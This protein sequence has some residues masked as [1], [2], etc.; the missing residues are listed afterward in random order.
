MLRLLGEVAADTGGDTGGRPV[1][2]GPAK[3]RLVLAALAV[4]A[5]RVVP[6]ERLAVRVW[7]EDVPRRARATLHSYISRLR[8]ALD[9][10]AD[11]IIE[12]RASGY[13][14]ISE[15]V[16]LHRFRALRAEAVGQADEARAERL[17]TEALQLWRGEA[18]TG[19]GG[20]WIEGER[21]RLERE[22]LDARRELADA[23]LRLGQ[24]EQ[25]V[26][27]LAALA[28]EHP[29]D[30]HVADQY[31][32][33]LHQA[34][35]TADALEHYR[36]VRDRLVEELGTDPGAALQ[37]LHRRLLA[38]DPELAATPAARVVPRQLPAAPAPF[39]GR[40][41]ELDRLGHKERISVIAGAGGIGKTWLALHWAHRHAAHFPDG[42]LFVDLRGFSPDTAPM[43]PVVAA[44][45]FLGG[46]GV[47][48]SQIPA[49]PHACSALFRSLIA[50]RRMLLVLD[51]AVDTA[52]VVPLLPGTERCKVVVTSRNRLSGL[53][54]AH[55]AHY[56]PLDVL[57]DVEAREL[58]RDRLGA[59]RTSAEH[60]AV[61]RLVALC[62]GFPLALTIVAAHA[63]TRPQLPLSVL[64][65]E[66]HDLGLSALED[67]DPTASLPSVLSWSHRALTP[68]EATAFGLLGAAPGPDISVHAA[69]SL[70]GLPVKDA[71]ALLRGL[72]Q[73]SLIS[74]DARGRFGMH[75]LVRRYAAEIGGELPEDA[76]RRLVDFH[77]HTAYACDRVLL[78]F[79]PPVELDPPAPGTHVQPP[80]ER[81]AAMLWFAAEHDCALALQQ[82][83]A[84]RG[85]HLSTWRIAWTLNT[86]VQVRLLHRDWLAVW[87]RAR[88]AAEHLDDPTTRILALQYFGLAQACLGYGHEGIG[89]LLQ[90]L[91]L[92][93]QQDDAAHQGH[94]HRA[95]SRACEQQGDD[96]AA[97]EHSAYALRF[98]RAL[99]NPV[100]LAAGL[101]TYGW[102][103]AKLGRFDEARRHCREALELHHQWAPSAEQANTL[104]SLGFIELGAG[105][106]EESITYYREA[107]ALYRELGNRLGIADPLEGLGQAYVAAGRPDEARQAWQEAVELYTQLGRDHDAQRM[108]EHIEAFDRAGQT[109]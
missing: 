37:E 21:A 64:A 97:M 59:A 50:E 24:G 32:R 65:D 55:G 71:R 34:G 63:Q 22:R 79:R 51:N 3:Q 70:L 76:L 82:A 40:E 10:V 95:L 93:A 101:N 2:L 14:L 35:R 46:L 39:V 13:A 81:A 11:V 49:D 102:D 58:V 87:E 36:E 7:G 60:D 30:E 42:Q 108:R 5:G 27:E 109:T 38:A 25:L 99:G 29:L 26:V 43:E 89:H 74:Q 98:Y 80:V 28:A 75:D 47:D 19:V 15:S 66:L 18:L 41:G 48:P 86:F 84:E 1:D 9:G 104:D 12:R 6:A 8:Q 100:W 44:R 72:E 31:M 68:D 45:G 56:V 33:A 92:A 52:H 62:G 85:W 67:E 23:R 17:L 73:A 107:L 105:N 96:T 77:L 103:L 57:S 94:I 20:E 106:H 78:P 91:A 4:D 69:A 53:V 90:A 88:E 61:E 54:T 16:D 83:T